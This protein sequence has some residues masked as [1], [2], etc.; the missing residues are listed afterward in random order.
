MVVAFPRVL[1]DPSTR[2]LASIGKKSYLINI[3]RIAAKAFIEAFRVSVLIQL[4]G[5]DVG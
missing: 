2:D 5:L 4:S 3:G 1:G